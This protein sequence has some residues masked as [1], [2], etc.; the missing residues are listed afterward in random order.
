MVMSKLAAL[1]RGVMAL[2]PAAQAI[3]F[4]ERWR[5]WG[6]LT[7]AMAG[8]ERIFAEHGAPPGARIGGLLR[9][10]PEIAALILQ[11]ITSDRC[12]VTLNP[13]LPDDKLVGEIA[14]LELPVL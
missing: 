8:L 9:N 3:E 4:D 12:I 5:S 13:A 10:T 1:V 11:V 7:A 14:T 6:E 2:D